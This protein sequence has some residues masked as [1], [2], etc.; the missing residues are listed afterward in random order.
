MGNIAGKVM[1]LSGFRRCFIAILAGVIGSFSMPS[2][3][4]FLSSFVSFTL[5]IW[6]LDGISSN[7]GRMSAIS[8]VGSSFFVGWLFGVGYFLAGLW[9]VR[10]GIVDQIG[11][12]FPFW[13]VVLFFVMISFLLAIFYG[14]A[15]S[16]ASLL[17]STGMG[18]ICVFACAVG[19]CE[20]L[21]SVLGIGTWNAIGYAAMPIPVM[22]QSVHWIGLF[23]MN[24]LSVFCFA[25]PALFGTRR[26]VNIGIILSSTLLILHIA[27]G[28]WILTEDSKSSLK[29]EKISPVIRIVQPG[30]NPAIKEDREK[31]LERYLSLTALPV[32]AGELE[33]VIIVWAYLPFPFSIVDQP[34]ILKKIASVL[35]IN[36]LLIVGSMR[37]E[38][39]DGRSHFYKSIY[40][41]NSKGEILI[42]SN[43]KHLVPFAEY[44]PYRNILKKLNLDFYMFPLD[45]SSSDISPLFGLSEKLRLYPLR[46]SDA[47]FHQD[48]NNLENVSAILNI[49]DD[50]GFMGSGT[51]HSFRYAQIQA[52]EIG[53]PL[54]RATNNGVSAFL[55]ERGQIISSVYAD[56]GASIDMHF[57]PKVR[58]SF[59]SSIQMR[60]FW[61]IEFILL[62]LAV[63]V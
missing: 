40:I 63:I 27:Y 1:L 37:K 51:D 50:S 32:S 9:W 60:V 33:P 30:I 16:L 53:L 39:V 12:R 7:L 10:E 49:I 19:F 34:S 11:S 6:L 18:R 13:G 35:K 55:D 59:R 21:R 8:R 57:Q 43:A 42:S 5:L 2:S 31:I 26:D 45:S 54:I 56:R 52:V 36:Q 20:W 3:D 25:S 47:L 62:I 23:G 61:I 17:W 28:W 48:I 22:M 38:L 4:L 41:I 15:T 58:D 46:F 24:A 44:L 14:V 29:F